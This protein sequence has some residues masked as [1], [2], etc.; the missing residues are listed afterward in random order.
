MCDTCNVSYQGVTV[1][2]NHTSSR[3]VSKP[4]NSGILEAPILD[5]CSP[6][7]LSENVFSLRH[8]RALSTYIRCNWKIKL[9]RN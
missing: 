1:Q 5:R 8:T 3:N 7:T 2:Y 4:L 6:K 9:F